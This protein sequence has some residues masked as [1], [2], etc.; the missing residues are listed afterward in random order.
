MRR[1]PDL[2][3]TRIQVEEGMTSRF[4][5]SCPGCNLSS[6]ESTRIGALCGF[7]R[8][9]ARALHAPVAAMLLGMLIGIVAGMVRDVLVCSS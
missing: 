3:F 9:K 6:G 7:R 5:L 2:H 1:L 8:G 4:L